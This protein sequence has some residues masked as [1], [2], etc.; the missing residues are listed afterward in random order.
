[1]RVGVIVAVRL[2]EVV[3]LADVE[4]DPVV[5]GLREAEGVKLLLFVGV[6]EGVREGLGSGGS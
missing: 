3:T 4:I 2:V 6:I 5:E 1:V